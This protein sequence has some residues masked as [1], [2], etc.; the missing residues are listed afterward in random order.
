MNEKINKMANEPIKSL[1]W[2]MGLPM[3]ISMVL[4]ALYNVV[5]SIFVSIFIFV[6][7]LLFGLLYSKS[8]I[9]LFANENEDVIMMGTIPI[10]E[11][12]TA[13]ISIFI[14]KKSYKEKIEIL[15]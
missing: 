14:L 9:C 12:F 13:I 1:L 4:Q 8:F 10:S 15:D 11:V 3:I 2:K 7:F 5:D 6:V